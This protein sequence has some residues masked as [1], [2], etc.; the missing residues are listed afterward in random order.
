M[1][2]VRPESLFQLRKYRAESTDIVVPRIKENAE[3]LGLNDKRAR[4][5]LAGSIGLRRVPK[6]DW[7]SFDSL[8]G[9]LTD[10]MK[11]QD[12]HDSVAIVR[13]VRRGR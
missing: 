2:T 12:T 4:A 9:V 6:K 10:T 3:L 13:R 11:H 1:R 7:S 5:R 8:Y